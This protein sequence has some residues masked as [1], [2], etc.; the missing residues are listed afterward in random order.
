MQGG[1]HQFDEQIQQFTLA[2]LHAEQPL[3][4]DAQTGD[5]LG[6]LEPQNLAIAMQELNHP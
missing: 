3:L 6:H 5:V 2:L 1:L 4:Q